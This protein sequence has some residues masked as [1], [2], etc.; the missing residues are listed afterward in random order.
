M[1]VRT[2]ETLAAPRTGAGRQTRLSDFLVCLSAANLCF[3]NVWAELQDRSFDIYRRFTLTGSL[4]A[5]LVLNI[6]LLTAVLWV[7]LFIARRRG[8]ERLLWCL[9]AGFLLVLC[10]P[11]NL[12]RTVLPSPA[13]PM[14]AVL[15]ALA[16]LTVFRWKQGRVIRGLVLVFT[17]FLPISLGY[18]AYALWKVPP[19][20]RFPDARP[21]AFVN[22]GP[23]RIVVLLFDEMDQ[24]LAFDARP[25]GIQ[26]PELDRLRSESFFARR[27]LPPADQTA[28]SVPALL[29]GRMLAGAIP[30]PPSDYALRYRGEAGA[31]A[32]ALSQAPTLF[33]E[34]RAA[35]FNVGIS[36]WYLPYCRI[37]DDFTE[38]S[39]QPPVGLMKR[40]EFDERLSIREAMRVQL[41]RQLFA[42]P[43]ASR[44]RIFGSPY[45]RSQS[46]QQEAFANIRRRALALAADGRLNLTYIHWNIPH[47]L[48]IYD[49]RANTLA[50]G[51]L[52]D[53]VDNLELV[54]RSL[55]EIRGVLE[56]TGNWND[57]A[58]L[59]T[60]DHPLRIADWHNP[61]GWSARM[62]QATGSK[63]R[64]HVPFILRLPGGESVEYGEAFNTVLTK[65]LALAYLRREINTAQDVRAWIDKHSGAVAVQ[66]A[67]GTSRS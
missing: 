61:G 47:P 53:Y 9:R 37:L 14:F 18:T 34:T 23:R 60:S 4:I 12:L 31:A 64:R 56:Q 22:A 54:D 58:I 33:S 40:E 38:C 2:A 67:G 44:L 41:W 7:P 29:T 63:Q 57:T 17:P 6:L 8:S 39:W 49:S 52:T 32:H 15:F 59:I 5:A 35:G 11:L 10:Y 48:G 28:M 3:L 24:Y 51:H 19:G 13:L 66:P 16:A 21:A 55:G 46:L 50:A 45:L 62:E 26:C 65:D 43:G 25:P 20:N 42:L 27:A 30:S 1:V 36:G